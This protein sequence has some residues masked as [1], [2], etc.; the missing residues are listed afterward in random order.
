MQTIKAF[1]DNTP[2]TLHAV[3][4]NQTV[5]EALQI[6]AANNI[7]ALPVLQGEHMVGIFSERDYARRVELQDR[8]TR[9]TRM[10]E[11]MT[12]EFITVSPE[13]NM[14][15]CMQIM[16]DKRV[17]HLPVMK[18]GKL[19]GLVSIGDVLFV[20]IAEQKLLIEQLHS[21]ITG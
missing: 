1:L 16:T 6:M 4:Q 17:R 13:Q 21:Y 3:Q 11:V 10:Q 12:S 7:G 19:V 8:K 15:E 2:R 14:D 9:E 20:M 18:D 5:W